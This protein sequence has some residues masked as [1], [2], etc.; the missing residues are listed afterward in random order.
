MVG[1]LL[2]LC[3]TL[4]NKS[5]YSSASCAYLLDITDDLLVEAVASGY[6]KDGHFGIDKGDGAVL[7]LGSWIALGMD[8]A[9]FLQFKCTFQC[10][11]IVVAST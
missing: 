8:V 6:D 11:G 3:V 5:R 9:D 7:H 4:G 2:Y 10:Y 1:K